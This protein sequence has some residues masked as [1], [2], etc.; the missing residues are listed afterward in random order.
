MTLFKQKRF[1]LRIGVGTGKSVLIIQHT[2]AEP[3][4][5]GIGNLITEFLAD[6]FILFCSLQSA[7]TIPTGTLQTIPNRLDHFLV[8]IQ[9]YRHINISLCQNFFTEL[10]DDLTVTVRIDQ[11]ANAVVSPREGTSK[12][13]SWV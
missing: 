10:S 6:A 2:M 3:F 1:P 7:G 9:S 11:K 8:L 13:I 5:F 12:H 4:I